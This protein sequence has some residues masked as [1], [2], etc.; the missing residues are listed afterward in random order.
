M[1]FVVLAIVKRR[2]LLLGM[3]DSVAVKLVVVGQKNEKVIYIR[4]LEII[5]KCKNHI[6]LALLSFIPIY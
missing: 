6:P 3:T 4:N 5:E 1:D 2:L